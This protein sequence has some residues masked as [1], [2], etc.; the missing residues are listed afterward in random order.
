MHAPEPTAGSFVVSSLA[1]AKTLLAS[2]AVGP[3][4]GSEALPQVPGHSASA[5]LIARGVA[6]RALWMWGKD[7]ERHA[8]VRKV[9]ATALAPRAIVGVLGENEALASKL[10]APVRKDRKMELVG[11]FVAPFI[12]QPLL[13]HF[14]VSGA[15][16][17]MLQGQFAM[18]APFVRSVAVV[19]NN[20]APYFALAAAAQMIGELW[21]A[22]QPREAYGARI[23]IDAVK[24]GTLTRDEAITH[25]ILLMFGNETSVQ[26][27]AGLIARMSE[28][29]ELW[30][31]VASGALAVEKLVEEGIRLGPPTNMTLVRTTTMPVECAGM[32]LAAGTDIR[33]PLGALNRDACAFADP[34][35]FDPERDASEHIAFGGGPTPC[36][37][38]HLARSMLGIAIRA[39]VTAYPACPRTQIIRDTIRTH[40]QGVVAVH[41]GTA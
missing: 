9:A 40:E 35:T 24:A 14:G 18:M 7:R 39:L 23:L 8:R 13:A 41:V 34:D 19:S 25:A 27:L 6:L 20:P 11:D 12:R 15:Q 2:P 21:E 10:L 29:P 31:A 1:Y 33:M 37:G 3:W 17:A 26:A 22:P 5:A 32:T 30:H 16:A 28:R 38:A 4:D 36:V